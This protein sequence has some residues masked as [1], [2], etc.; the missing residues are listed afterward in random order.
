[1]RLAF[2]HI[3]EHGLYP[4]PIALRPQAL[5]LLKHGTPSRVLCVGGGWLVW[6]DA[7]LLTGFLLK[8]SEGLRLYRF[9]F[10]KAMPRF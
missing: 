5:W 8:A 4:K 7:G 3:H 10:L 2:P 1:M 9:S 6:E